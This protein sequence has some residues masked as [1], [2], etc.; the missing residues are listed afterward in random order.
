MPYTPFHFGP[1][2]LIKGLIPRQFSLSTFSLANV[3]MDVEPL[4]HLIQGD[5]Q[6]HGVS[7]T[8]V[9]AAC[10]AAA[11]A[12][13]APR[14][15]A[16]AER[17]YQKRHS[18][19]GHSLQMTQQQAW[20]SALLGSGSHLLLDATMHSDMHMFLPFSA[21]NPLLHPTWTQNVY[22]A[23]VLMGM[24]GMLILLLRMHGQFKHPQ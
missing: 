8:L 18:H 20:L 16:Y 10:I 17:W 12:L 2:M 7:H 5:A 1:G 21:A 22:L 13:A 23:C 24:T 14:M 11:T 15:L 9:G 19:S 4:Y 6:L 3:A